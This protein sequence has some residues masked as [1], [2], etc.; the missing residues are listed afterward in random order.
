MF[1]T[2]IR[3]PPAFQ[4]PSTTASPRNYQWLKSA[5]PSSSPSLCMPSTPTMTQSV[6]VL[7]S[8]A[9]LFS[10]FCY[11]FNC[12][13]YSPVLFT[14]WLKNIQGLTSWTLDPNHTYLITTSAVAQYLACT[15]IYNSSLVENTSLT[16][17]DNYNGQCHASM[18]C[19]NKILVASVSEWPFVQ[20]IASNDI[21]K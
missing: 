14:V 3:S 19:L 10:V 16:L 11:A 15:V 21:L 5:S 6:S 1:N 8:P 2:Y 17:Q 13:S 7:C 20:C 12:N 18:N 4:Q 9:K